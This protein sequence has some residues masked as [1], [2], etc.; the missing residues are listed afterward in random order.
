[1]D[2]GDYDNDNNHDDNDD[3]N[4]DDGDINNDEFLNLINQFRYRTG[5]FKMII[6]MMIVMKVMINVITIII[7]IKFHFN[8]QSRPW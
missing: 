8:N 6:I 2:N 7:M 3:D 5:Q 4:Y 1:M